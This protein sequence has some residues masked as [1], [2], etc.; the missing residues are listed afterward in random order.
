MKPITWGDILK[1]V[2]KNEQLTKKYSGKDAYNYINE[3]FGNIEKTDLFYH[4]GK[5][6]WYKKTVKTVTPPVEVKDPEPLKEV[7]HPKKEQNKEETVKEVVI[8]KPSCVKSPVNN[9]KIPD[10]LPPGTIEIIPELKGGLHR[11][12]FGNKKI[13]VWSIDAVIRCTDK[14]IIGFLPIYNDGVKLS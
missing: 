1:A 13:E 11:L 12:G 14:S 10:A 5:G 4:A 8:N 9:T 7:E 3:H 6:K 2:E